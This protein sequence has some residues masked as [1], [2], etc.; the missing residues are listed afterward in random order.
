M[1]NLNEFVDFYAEYNEI[2]KT[3]AKKE[4]GRFTDTF[5]VATA[6]KGGVNLNGFAKS[7]IVELAACVRKNPKTGE[8]INVPAKRMVK[9]K[10]ASKFKN[11][12]VE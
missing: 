6:K 2:T 8:D 3:A 1:L 5:R 4:I 9:I 10:L 7:E 11:L 12:E